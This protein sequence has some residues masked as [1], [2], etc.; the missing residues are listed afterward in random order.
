MTMLSDRPQATVRSAGPVSDAER[1]RLEEA[2]T[3]TPEWRDWGPYLSERA[4]GT[5]RE[6]YSAD[7]DAWSFFPHEHA[8]SRVYR[9]NEDGM[10]GFSDETQNW[11][12][13]LGLW[14]GV[15]PILKERM[16]G[17]TGPQGNHGEDVKAYW[18]YLDGTPHAFLAHLALPLPAAGVPLRR[19]GRRERPPGQAGTRIRVGR[20]RCIRRCPVLGGHRRLRQ[21]RPRDLLMKITV[22][23]AGPDEATLRV[24]PTFWFRNTWSWGIP[25]TRSRACAD[26]IPRPRPAT[27]P[28]PSPPAML[29]RDLRPQD[30]LGRCAVP[31]PAR[32]SRA[33]HLA[34]KSGS[35]AARRCTTRGDVRRWAAQRGWL[36][37]CGA[38]ILV[39]ATQLR[40]RSR[41]S[42]D[43]LPGSAR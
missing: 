41:A 34:G 39:V 32:T 43:G 23:N 5:V 6:D 3:G 4:W 12:L 31:V 8:R 21:G 20:H 10:A 30:G 11:C 9:W 25:I 28:S 7:G 14:N 37:S 35:L 42:A 17:L 13:S 26:L 15:D 16:F 1:L 2:G 22:E 36:C 40:S 33:L 38:G 24:L 27:H 18:W 29:C 19:P